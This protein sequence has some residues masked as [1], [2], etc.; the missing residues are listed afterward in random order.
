MCVNQKRGGAWEVMKVGLRLSQERFE[1]VRVYG[2]V[3]KTILVV[4]TSSCRLRPLEKEEDIS[5]SY[6][7]LLKST[8]ENTTYS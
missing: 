1:H 6:N 4:V 8:R 5:S 2:L 3:K 7:F